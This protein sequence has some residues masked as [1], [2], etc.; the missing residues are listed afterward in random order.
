VP[1]FVC[2]HDATWHFSPGFGLRITRRRTSDCYWHVY[3]DARSIPASRTRGTLG[4]LRSSAA[5]GGQDLVGVHTS[6][7]QL[8]RWSICAV[9]RHQN[10]RGPVCAS[11]GHAHARVKK[12]SSV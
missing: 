3:S 5:G 9:L 11:L 7:V 2:A 12:K 4:A 10:L 1:S 8:H 6:R